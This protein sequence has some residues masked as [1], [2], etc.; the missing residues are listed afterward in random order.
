[1]ANFL[2]RKLY[3]TEIKVDYSRVSFSFFINFSRNKKEKNKKIYRFNPRQGCRLRKSALRHTTNNVHHSNSLS[4]LCG[5]HHRLFFRL[6]PTS[7]KLTVV[8]HDHG[9]CVGISI[10]LQDRRAG[11]DM[12]NMTIVYAE[13]Q[14][15]NAIVV[16]CVD[17]G[18][19]GRP[20]G[21]SDFVQK[22]SSWRH[23]WVLLSSRRQYKS[24][25][26]TPKALMSM[27][28]PFLQPTTVAKKIGTA[29]RPR[30]QVRD[31]SSMRAPVVWR[32]CLS[33]FF[34]PG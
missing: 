4:Q 5:C 32:A 11:A 15:G 24:S 20:I 18:R 27:F 6:H 9:P 12:Q 31:L 7:C 23:S 14:T 3:A 13:T 2:Y 8:Y 22:K 33:Q 21:Q 29:T 1:M 25:F 26:S 10:S 30:A 19:E 34:W 16:K 17:S 28:L